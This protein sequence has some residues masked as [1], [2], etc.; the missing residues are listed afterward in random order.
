MPTKFQSVNLKVRKFQILEQ[1]ILKLI[2]SKFRGFSLNL[3]GSGYG[4]V[5]CFCEGGHES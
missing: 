1:I 2:T 3:R 4:I 5:K